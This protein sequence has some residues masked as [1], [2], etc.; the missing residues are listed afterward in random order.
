[1]FLHGPRPWKD[2]AQEKQDG[3][4]EFTDSS[5]DKLEKQPKK[6]RM[7]AKERSGMAV[8]I[9]S[10]ETGFKSQAFK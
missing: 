4:N 10:A 7:P 6:K 5:D 3:I 2:K 1:M 9:I 8:P